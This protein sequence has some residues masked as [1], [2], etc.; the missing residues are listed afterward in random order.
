MHRVRVL[1]LRGIIPHRS[2]SLLFAG[3]FPWQQPARAHLA[4]TGMRL[5]RSILISFRVTTVPSLP[6]IACPHVH[7]LHP[8]YAP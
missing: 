7:T 2:C 8:K 6:N 1:V 4:V 5:P 3:T